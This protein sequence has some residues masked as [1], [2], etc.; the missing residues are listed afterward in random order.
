MFGEWAT[1]FPTVS[2]DG[3]LLMSVTQCGFDDE[4]AFVHWYAYDTN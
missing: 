3:K 1:H 2:T 4:T